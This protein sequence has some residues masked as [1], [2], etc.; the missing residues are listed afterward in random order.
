MDS[1]EIFS[2]GRNIKCSDKIKI[3]HNAT[4]WRLH[5]NNKYYRDGSF[6]EVV[7]CHKARN[8]TDWYPPSRNTR[9][10]VSTVSAELYTP[11]HNLRNG[12]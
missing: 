3:V 10:I 4:G 1:K 8:D 5:A 9:F 12:D 2:A 11:S 6:N 7:S